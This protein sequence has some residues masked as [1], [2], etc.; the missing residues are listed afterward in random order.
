M[1]ML[2]CIMIQKT[3]QVAD[4]AESI[5]W[6]VIPSMVFLIAC[7]AEEIGIRI[8]NGNGINDN[9]AMQLEL[10]LLNILETFHSF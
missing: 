3:N 4:F 6:L 5:L 9:C 7:T 1:S 2:G 8:C 10:V